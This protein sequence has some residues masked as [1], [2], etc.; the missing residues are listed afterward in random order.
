MESSNIKF[1][2][3]QFLHF[4]P[5]DNKT[6]FKIWKFKFKIFA[7]IFNVEEAFSPKCKDEEKF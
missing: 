4:N 1:D 5:N 2:K 3:L 7:T 6:S